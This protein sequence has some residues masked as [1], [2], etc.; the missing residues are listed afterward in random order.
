M[1]RRLA[2]DH[3][4]NAKILAGLLTRVEGVDIVALRDVGLQRAADPE[5]LEWIDRQ[6]RVLLSHDVNTM[7]RHAYARLRSE[8]SIP[9]LVIVPQSLSVGRAVA[10]LEVVIETMAPEEVRDRILY[11]PL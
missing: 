10:E 5:V 2:A 4:F 8:R 11:L 9:G 6:D 7:P 3:D 1:L